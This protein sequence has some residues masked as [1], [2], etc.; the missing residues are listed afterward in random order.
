MKKPLKSWSEVEVNDVIQNIVNKSTYR[1]LF[2]TKIGC[3]NSDYRVVGMV[4]LEDGAHVTNTTPAK[5]Y[6]KI[7]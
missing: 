7:S 3:M 4:C 1:I 2:I 6:I 5:H